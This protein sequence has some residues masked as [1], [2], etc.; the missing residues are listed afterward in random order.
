MKT[1]KVHT[2]WV[3]YSVIEVEAEDADH[4]IE[5]V[6]DGDYDRDRE[7]TTGHGLCYGYDDETVIEVEEVKDERP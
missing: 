6:E 5:R 2:K 4:A 1:F 7:I 3:G